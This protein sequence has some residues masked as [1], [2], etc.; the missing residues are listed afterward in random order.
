MLQKTW[1]CRCLY[2]NLTYIPSGTLLGVVLLDHM[3]VLFL[4][5]GGSLHTVFHNDVLISIST[6]SM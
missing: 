2:C 4:G 5:F 6:K 3:V 1:M